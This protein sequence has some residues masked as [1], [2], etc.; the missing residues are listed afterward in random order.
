MLAILTGLIFTRVSAQEIMAGW[1]VNSLTGVLTNATTVK[2]T[3]FDPN[4]TI[5]P[6]T[7]GF[8]ISPVTTSGVFGGNNW[9]NS[10]GTGV[11]DTEA[12]SI[13]DG[14]Y[15]TYSVQSIPGF[16]V[17][18]TTNVL[19]WHNS[20]T[21]PWNGEL[22]Y[23]TDGINYTDIAFLAYTNGNFAATASLTNVLAGI[24][25]LQNVPSTVTNFFRLVNWGATASGGT[26]YVNNATPTTMPD[27]QVI[28]A[29]TSLGTVAPT[30]V[31]VS[32]TSL[33]QPVDAGQ[34]VIFTASAQGSPA[35]NFWYQI[36]G[37]ETNLIV[38][39]D[40][41]TLTLTDVLG[42]NSGG[43]FAVL[44]NAAGS[45]T[46]SVV[47]LT[48]ID[49]IIQVQPS[50][51]QGLVDGQAQFAVTVAGTAPAF[52]WYFSDANG[53]LIA[54]AVSLGDASVISGAKS[55][56]LTIANLQPQDVTNFVVVVSNAYGAVTSS[57]ASLLPANN[58]SGTLPL[59]QGMIAFWDFDGSQFTNTALDPNSL[60]DPTPFLG[61]GTASAVG[62]CFDPGTSPGS[63]ATD[64]SDVAGVFTPFGFDQPAPNFSWVTENY[65]AVTGTNKQNGVQFL[66]STVGAK[67]I[68]VSYDSRT[69]S[70]ASEYERLQY[71]TNG[72]DWID[73]PASSTFSGLSGS[74]DA[75]FH[76]FSYS[77]V[78]FPGVDNN[79][80][81]G[82]RVVTEWQSTATYGIGAT[83]FWVGVANS[84]TSGASG[85]S[86]AG[87]V[88]YDLV[89]IM[90]DAITNNNTPPVLSTFENMPATN[91]LS[92]TNMVDTNT[93]VLN[94]SASDLQMPASN[95]TFSVQSLNT[96]AAGVFNPTVT[97]NLT[98][99]NT[100]STNFALSISFGGD[101]IPNPMDA[102]PILLTATD[103]NGESTSTW[104]LLTVSA[105]NQPP[106]NSLTAL[107]STNTVANKRLV[108]PFLVGSA[109]N[110]L[111]NLTYTVASDNNTVIPAGNIVV[112]GNTNTGNMTLTI[113][114]AADQVGE[115]LISVSVNDNDPDE[116]RSTTANIAVMVRPNTNVVAVD[117]FNYDN[118]GALD[119][120]ADNYWQHLSGIIGQLQVG[121]DVA[122][123][124]DGDTEN[125]EA[126][127][128]GGSYKTN[129]GTVLYY[130]VVVNMNQLPT[131]DGSYIV[132][133]N[134]GS[135]NTADVEDC[136]VT[137]TNDAAPGDYRLGIANASGGTGLTA[138]I[139][140]L[141]LVPG[142][143]YTVITSLVLSNGFSTLW[144]SPTNESSTAVTNTTPA[145]TATNLFNI[146]DIELRE[147]GEDEGVINV[148][149]LIA[150]TTFDSV[151]YPPAANPDVVAVTENSSA[152]LIN[153]LINDGG[154]GLS[155][156]SVS[157]DSN[158]T[159]AISGT[160][161]TFTPVNDFVGTSTIG[162]TIVDNV[163]NT[164]SSTIT[165]TVTN[166]PPL[167]N[168]VSESVAENSVNNLFN[169]LAND[170]VETSGGSLS[171]VSVSETDGN[172]TASV[173]GANVVFTPTTGF[174]GTANIA[175]TITDNIGGTN[176]STIAVSVGN[177]ATPIPVTAQFSGGN[178]I[179]NWTNP[180]FILQT[181]TNVMGP[182]LTIP[183]ATSPYTN[184][185]GTNPASFFRLKN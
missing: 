43:Y 98:V 52:Q 183:G 103:T 88:T 38:G 56:L 21:G 180:A 87:T 165:V 39:A 93:L 164:S 37:N 12:F 96:L 130:S 177:L 133:F 140:P 3:V 54:P 31:T 1:A 61:V 119:S 34:T 33:N 158:G 86:A 70:T 64:P 40:S 66:A 102:A 162:Y 44:T 62:T 69:S 28:G 132:M 15:L 30:N 22:Q 108:V 16:F 174:T 105:I 85:N 14:H 27:F 123:V 92:F 5:T 48:V 57:V 170:V 109:R 134:D 17:S 126:G 104:F 8:G 72:M 163:G 182:Y 36:V 110:P 26:W 135:G 50:S 172:G 78:G 25:A 157:P 114:P 76:N 9:T 89:A 146:A 45:A 142:N 51:A 75:G 167:A 127:L 80:N 145:A 42:A 6:L 60:N 71:T 153:P 118:S 143:N 68:H 10:G 97:P 121:D 2:P 77:L 82:I 122:T 63:G 168:P 151:F 29:V 18:F 112:G 32:A 74:G 55:S 117:Y 155:L 107:G 58:A 141:D 169:P 115:A 113:T 84:Y 7:K 81:F 120:V 79:P 156:V 185:I 111:T 129:S 95:L 149:N 131:G 41:P 152:N 13:A 128:L 150:G 178:I 147:S 154:S 73:Y 11:H 176:S 175:Y 94:F 47:N 49:P 160:N 91:G 166:I 59:T 116:P 90:G 136:L 181:S 4:L 125:L 35:T 53:N 144:I 46:S 124:S 179:L 148:G 67:N 161:V 106:T 19:F 159:A 137:T 65:P 100:G 171:L 24:P 101:F 83:N 138:T 173:T 139:F 184:L 23:S 99:A 20:A